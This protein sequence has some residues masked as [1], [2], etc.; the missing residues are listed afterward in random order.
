MK[1]LICL[2]S[3]FIIASQCIN[4]YKH[5]YNNK[6]QNYEIYFN[7]HCEIKI[8]IL[9]YNIKNKIIRCEE[10]NCIIK[11]FLVGNFINKI[12]TGREAARLNRG[13]VTEQ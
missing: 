2:Q 5:H 10:K 7:L 1:Y 8:I 4:Y 9:I 11:I 13:L 3:C 12:K 6:F